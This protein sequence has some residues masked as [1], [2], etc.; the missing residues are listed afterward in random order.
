ME[1]QSTITTNTSMENTRPCMRFWARNFDLMLHTIVIV[2]IWNLIHKESIR[3]IPNVV[4]TVIVTFIYILIDWL[5]MAILGTTPGKKILGIKVRTN[6]GM[7]LTNEVA[8]KRA[9]M[10]WFRGMGVGVGIIQ[11]IANIKGYQNLTRDNI[12]TW[13]RDLDILVTHK[14]IGLIR[15]LICP[16]IVIVIGIIPL[17]NIV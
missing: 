17:M 14:R 1:E 4:A 13:D 5:Y 11:I 10:V 12:T 16:V 15:L 9:L 8:F 7:K 3:S 6:D 2:I